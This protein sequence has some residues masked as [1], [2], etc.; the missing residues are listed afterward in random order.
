VQYMFNI[1]TVLWAIDYRRMTGYL[2]C[3]PLLSV[4]LLLWLT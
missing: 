3:I 2:I 1:D 4:Q